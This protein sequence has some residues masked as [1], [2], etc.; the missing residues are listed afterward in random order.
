M[1]KQH[2]RSLRRAFAGLLAAAMLITSETEILVAAP[3]AA[4]TVSEESVVNDA[5]AGTFDGTGEVQDTLTFFALSPAEIQYGEDGSNAKGNLD[6]LLAPKFIVNNEALTLGEDYTV[7]Y[8]FFTG[9]TPAVYT[10]EE[11]KAAEGVSLQTINAGTVVTAVALAEQIP[12]GESDASLALVASA[13]FTIEKREVVVRYTAPETA[14]IDGR[15]VPEDGRYVLSA[16]EIDYSGLTIVA[17]D[18]DSFAAVDELN[19]ADAITGDI[20][21]DVSS[22]D[23]TEDGYQIVPM[24]LTLTDDFNNN[25]TVINNIN[26]DIY[27]KKAKYYV[28][29]TINNNGEQWSKTYELTSGTNQAVNQ[30]SFYSEMISGYKAFLAKSPDTCLLGWSVYTDSFNINGNYYGGSSYNTTYLNAD[31]YTYDDGSKVTF[32]LSGNKDYHFVGNVKRAAAEEIFVSAIPAVY[33]DGR[34][35]VAVGTKG[36]AKKQAADLR[37]RV[38]RYGSTGSEGSVDGEDADSGYALTPG[39]DY[40][41]TYK[42]NTKASMQLVRD[43]SGKEG[44]YVKTWGSNS[45]RPVAIITGKGTYAGF[46]AEAYFDIL[47]VSLGARDISR[48]SVKDYNS[49]NDTYT[50]EYPY[51]YT[52]SYKAQLSKSF[53]AT[54]LLKNGKLASKIK[55]PKVTKYFYTYGYDQNYK[56]INDARFT[57]TLKEGTDYVAEIYLWNA[58]SKSWDKQAFTDPNKI[59]ATGNYLYLI[60]GIGNYCGAVYDTATSRS[61]SSD[62]NFD[63]FSDGKTEGYSANPNVS[64]TSA[65]QFLVTDDTSFDLSKAK[66]TIK[67]KSL[68]YKD[69][70]KYGAT[71]FQISVKNSAGKEITLGTDY[72][73]SFSPRYS[74]YNSADGITSG[75][76]IGAAN[77]YYVY[78]YP[79]GN[80][81]A[82]KY[83]GKVKI[84]GLKLKA[85]YFEF[86]SK[87]VPVGEVPTCSISAAGASAGLSISNTSPYYV[88]VY[89]KSYSGYEPSAKKVTYY[90]GYGSATGY[91]IDPSKNVKLSYTHKSKSLQQAIKDG[92][93]A[94]TVPT[95]GS[96]N[97]KGAMPDGSI[98]IK[99]KDSTYSN[100]IYLNGNG[101]RSGFYVYGTVS[102]EK[103]STIGY[104]YV[105]LSVKGNTKVGG[106]ATITAKGSGVYTGSATIG[107]FTV[108]AL[109]VNY[110]DAITPYSSYYSRNQVYA[111]FEDEQFGKG[112][113]DKPK[114]KLYQAYYDGAKRTTQLAP[115]SA[116]QYS[117]AAGTVH[118][119]H[120]TAVN[121]S[122]GTAEGFNFKS[123][124]TCSYFGLY[125]KSGLPA[126]SKVTIDGKSYD[127]KG[128]VISGYTPTFTGATI[129]PYIS[130]VT[131]A[132]GDV[133]ELNSDDFYILYGQNITAKQNGGTITLITK[134]NSYNKRYPYKGS[135]TLKFTIAPSAKISM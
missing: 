15:E 88:S 56:R 130:S 12:S 19:A 98:S 61:S 95:T 83:A 126:V 52:N 7:S 82:S 76:T 75:T 6:K 31:A 107:T 55:V 27:V 26:G 29:F 41:I 115:L 1:K 22:L 71:D 104:E 49:S 101:Q 4:D 25:F 32:K 102:N 48:M 86:S 42:N 123:G 89:T 122:N 44:T 24:E 40:T 8:K 51:T 116:A 97:V 47:P 21:L 120:G 65:F 9:E 105:T 54:Y 69:N 63:Y 114:V 129:A 118:S 96:Y 36:S 18:G 77:E 5:V 53:D 87:S 2:K 17:Q 119:D 10:T 125:D 78:I 100:S 93:I 79:Q 131:L 23:V 37:I 91:A 85:N 103:N 50:Y 108:K 30:Y 35:H 117:A 20:I 28:T 3:L 84:T 111:I 72:Y 16:D 90:I 45:D 39:T 99:Y 135:V 81:F 11:F 67:K 62:S 58:A 73:V 127:V 60:R 68:P 43:A 80:Y 124:L 70:T 38:Y 132:S 64:S 34:A 33:Y 14:P 57:N 113:L 13:E 106:T 128:G 94:F 66:V 121:I 110:I 133:V 74:H 109:D 92:D 134:Y 59:T 112:S 46:S